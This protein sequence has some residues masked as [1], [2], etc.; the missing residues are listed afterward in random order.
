MNAQQLII[1][2]LVPITTGIIVLWLA[3]RV[4]FNNSNRLLF[5]RIILLTA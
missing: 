5:N 4:L 2:Q 1:N 3:Y